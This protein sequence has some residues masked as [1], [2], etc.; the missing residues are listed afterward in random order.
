MNDPSGISGSKS[1]PGGKGENI[2][3]FL[4]KL[5]N[6]LRESPEGLSGSNPASR[7]SF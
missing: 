5:M 3:C 6:E 4:A 1:R 2:P 7:P